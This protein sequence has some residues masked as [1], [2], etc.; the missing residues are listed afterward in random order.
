MSYSSNLRGLI[1][2]DDSYSSSPD[3][4]LD[5]SC[6]RG[7]MQRDYSAMPLGAAPY[8]GKL[9]L[10]LIPRKDW[11]EL[12]RER[13][14]KKNR[15]A[16]KLDYLGVPV[17]DQ[18]QTN[19]CWANGPT[20][21]VEIVRALNM[22]GYESLSAASVAAPVKN[23]RNVGGWGAQALEFIVSDGIVSESLWPNAVIDKS[24][25]TPEAKANAAKHKVTEWWDLEPNNLD[26]LITCL[27]MG[28]PVAIGLDWWGHEV[29][30]ID[31]VTDGKD[32]GV[33][34]DNSWGMSWGD[35]GRGVLMG[36]KALPGDAVCARVA[37]VT[38]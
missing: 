28:F 35:K 27:L 29:T 37:M 3:S 34:I 12:I 16:D 8:A 26:E 32:F 18:K 22:Q 23:F 13:E 30:A 14:E 7:Y 25:W 21:C 4:Y 31:P 5:P 38:T 1:V 6:G 2:I 33:L 19:Y 17:K 15:L 36:K 10:P 24:L 11:P 20:H 9:P